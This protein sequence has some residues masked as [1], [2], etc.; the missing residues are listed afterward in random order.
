MDFTTLSPSDYTTITPNAKVPW[1]FYNHNI[2]DAWNY[3][4][5]TGITI[6]VIDSGLSP[7]QSLMNSS[8]NDGLSSGR[9]ASTNCSI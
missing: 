9:T 6:G 1:N 2:P 4:T 3:S 7:N 5:G 8:F